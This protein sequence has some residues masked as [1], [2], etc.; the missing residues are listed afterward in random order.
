[1]DEFKS[2]GHVSSEGGKFD[3]S[4]ELNLIVAAQLSEQ[5]TDEVYEA[6]MRSYKILV[7]DASA[8]RIDSP[9]RRSRLSSSGSSRHGTSDI[10]I[11]DSTH[12]SDHSPLVSNLVCFNPEILCDF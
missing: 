11:T 2:P 1:L 10:S 6:L 7:G 9:P 8:I 4:R 5:I 12:Q 3:F